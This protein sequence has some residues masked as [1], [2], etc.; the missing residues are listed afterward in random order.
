MKSQISDILRFDIPDATNNFREYVFELLL[1]TELST[2]VL[3]IVLNAM[4]DISVGI[5]KGHDERLISE[6]D[7]WEGLGYTS[8]EMNFIFYK[9]ILDVAYTRMEMIIMSSEET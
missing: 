5:K 2:K 9:S 7:Y 4:T 8:T 6:I 3:V 1:K